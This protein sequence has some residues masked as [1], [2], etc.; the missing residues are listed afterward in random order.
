M[1]PLDTDFPAPWETFPEIPCGS[2]H[3]RMG[4]GEDVMLEWWRSVK[5]LT[6]E[7]RRAWHQR[8]TPPPEWAEWVQRGFTRIE[9]RGT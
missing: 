9:E 5:R 1:T 8:H 7:E 4:P 2:I 3:W 6:A